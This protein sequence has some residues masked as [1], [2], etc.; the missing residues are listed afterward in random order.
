MIVT[1]AEA[2]S[3]ALRPA[4]LEQVDR[5]VQEQG[6]TAKLGLLFCGPH[7]QGIAR[8]HFQQRAATLSTS[9]QRVLKHL[10][11]MAERGGDTAWGVSQAVRGVTE[12]S[13]KKMRLRL[14]RVGVVAKSRY[15]GY[16]RPNPRKAVEKWI[17]VRQDSEPP[18]VQPTLGL[19]EEAS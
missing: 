15:V 19:T 3:W 12:A 16:D 5:E 17:A 6:P 1:A 13:A 11:G 8:Q 18:P 9:E 10:Q 2:A 4:M 14:R 7:A